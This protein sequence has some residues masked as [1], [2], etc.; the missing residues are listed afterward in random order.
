MVTRVVQL[1][2]HDLDQQARETQDWVQ[3]NK[4]HILNIAGPRESKRPEIWQ[5]SMSF[6]FALTFRTTNM[7]TAA[8]RGK[9]IQELVAMLA[10]GET[11]APER[12]RTRE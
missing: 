9:K 6:L 5:R 4:F 11:I 12:P 1:E 8:G 3:G 10:R 2:A 7:K